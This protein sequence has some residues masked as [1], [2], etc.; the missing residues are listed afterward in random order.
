MGQSGW[1]E[2]AYGTVKRDNFGITAFCHF[3][4]AYV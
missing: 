4:I 3:Y 2:A 1:E